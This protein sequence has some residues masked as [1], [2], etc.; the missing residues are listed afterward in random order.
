M[1]HAR[2]QGRPPD[3]WSEFEPDLRAMFNKLCGYC[4][5]FVMKGQIDHFIPVAVLKARGQEHLSYEWDNLRYGEGVL[6]QRKSNHLVLDP[7]KVKDD[8]FEILLPSLQLV[9]TSRVPKTQRKLAEFTIEKLGLRDSEVVVRYRRAWFE[10]YQRRDLTLEGLE[11][12][13]PGIAR[14]VGRDLAA[15]KDWRI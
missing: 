7:F 6:N 8:W 3:Y 4:A 10:L 11:K 9:V 2:F 15:G 12:V 5:M 1:K 14:A 13:A